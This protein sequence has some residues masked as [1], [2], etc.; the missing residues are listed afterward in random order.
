MKRGERIHREV[1]RPLRQTGLFIKVNQNKV[2]RFSLEDRALIEQY[3]WTAHATG[4]GGWYAITRMRGDDGRPRWMCCT[5]CSRFFVGDHINGNGLDNRRTNLRHA[6]I[7]Q[8][9]ANTRKRNNAESSRFKGVSRTGCRASGGSA[10]D[11][12]ADRAATSA[13]TSMSAKLAGLQD[14]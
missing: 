9:L 7:S 14:L 4:C 5:T 11:R 13:R 1:Y 8:N 12:T 2:I 6:T 10:A 3:T